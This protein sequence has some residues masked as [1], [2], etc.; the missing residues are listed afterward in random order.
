PRRGVEPPAAGRQPARRDL[1]LRINGEGQELAHVRTAAAHVRGNLY[2]IPASQAAYGGSVSRP[3][4]SV[5]ISTGLESRVRQ[6]LPAS[7]AP[8]VLSDTVCVWADMFSAMIIP[9]P[10]AVTRA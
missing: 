5:G 1:R 8:A 4:A 7:P 6:R 3:R 9:E 10:S 2:S